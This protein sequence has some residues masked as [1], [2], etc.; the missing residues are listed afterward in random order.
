MTTSVPGIGGAVA[1]DVG[2]PG[3][4][5]TLTMSPAGPSPFRPVELL[6]P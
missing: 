5:Y 6:R 1:S 2:A 4:G 3:A